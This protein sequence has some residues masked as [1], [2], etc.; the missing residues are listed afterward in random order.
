MTFSLQL[1]SNI[2]N[3]INIFYTGNK[4]GDVCEDDFDND[5]VSNRMD[6]C[7][8][9]PAINATNFKVIHSFDIKYKR[10]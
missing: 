4:V 5:G 7:P 9:N 6:I 1:Q 8:R 10:K 2:K 3:Y